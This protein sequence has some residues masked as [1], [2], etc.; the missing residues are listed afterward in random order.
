MTIDEYKTF[1]ATNDTSFKSIDE[2][3]TNEINN[4]L[5]KQIEILFVNEK[6]E[7]Y[8]SM[9]NSIDALNKVFKVQCLG[10][11]EIISSYPIL[12]LLLRATLIPQITGS[13]LECISNMIQIQPDVYQQQIFQYSDFIDF[14]FKEINDE[15]SDNTYYCI[16]LIINLI[17]GFQ[18]NSELFLRKLM[19]SFQSNSV[20]GFSLESIKNSELCLILMTKVIKFMSKTKIP[21]NI[22]NDILKECILI[23]KEILEKFQEEEYKEPEYIFFSSQAPENAIR[24]KVMNFYNEM[25]NNYFLTVTTLLDLNIIKNIFDFITPSTLNLIF[26]AISFYFIVVN[27]GINDEEYLKISRCILSEVNINEII[28]WI[29]DLSMTNFSCQVGYS[30]LYE[31]IRNQKKLEIDVIDAITESSIVGSVILNFRK[32]QCSF[33]QKVILLNFIIVFIRNADP[34]AITEDGYVSDIF[35]LFDYLIDQHF[36]S[37]QMIKVIGLLLTYI[38]MLHTHRPTN[39]ALQT[40]LG[41]YKIEER[42]NNLMLDED[43]Q[44]D[45]LLIGHI[46]VVLKTISTFTS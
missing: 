41:N 39:E 34:I 40:L 5:I 23:S 35:I 28:E 14:L 19:E 9:K 33:K 11:Y 30:L 2:F 44:E 7:N 12:S 26:A 21:Q 6:K 22:A 16:L 20:L 4:D 45:D 18:S 17:E 31:L 46:K 8:E 13:A 38:D 1:Q 42:L 32:E 25:I 10:L 36:E 29:K 15:E 3:R 24:Y 37:D 43:Y 27:Q